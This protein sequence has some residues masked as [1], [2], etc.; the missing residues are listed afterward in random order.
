MWGCGQDSNGSELDWMAGPCEHS[1]ECNFFITWVTISFSE[2][3]FHHRVSLISLLPVRTLK[4]YM[5]YAIY[6]NK[7]GM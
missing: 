6:L 4:M 3:T 5:D 1:N 7:N 2:R